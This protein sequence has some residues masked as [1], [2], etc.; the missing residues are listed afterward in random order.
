MTGELSR[1]ELS[2]LAEVVLEVGQAML[3]SGATSYRTEKT[4]AQ[5]GLGLGADRLELYVTPTGVITT[6]ISGNEQRT[7]V[8]RVG[9]LGVNMAQTLALRQLATHLM[10]VGGTLPAVREQIAIIRSRPRELPLWAT[11]PAVGIACGAFAEILGAGT[12]EFIA[13]AVGAGLAQT[14]RLMLHRAH[15]NI[16]ALTV[17]CALAGSLIAWGVCQIIHSDQVELAVIASVLLLVPG[18]PLVTS[19]LDLSNNDLVSGVTRG[20]LALML[21]LSIGVGVLLTLSITGLR[22]T[23]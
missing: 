17:I 10:L 4:M 6:A 2:E 16:F 21:A 8:A 19:V 7:R 23:P 5:V 1:Q 22:I 11:I 20:T 15:V 18:V 9:A 12:G 3:Q 13:A 14:V